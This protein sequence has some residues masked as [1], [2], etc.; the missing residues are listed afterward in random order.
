V[1]KYLGKAGEYQFFLTIDNS[2]RIVTSAGK[3]DPL[4][5]ESYSK[6]DSASVARF[7]KYQK[8]H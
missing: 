3:I 5:I 8:L 6:Q 4:T 1:Y 2:E 7:K